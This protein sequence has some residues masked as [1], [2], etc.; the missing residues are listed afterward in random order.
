MYTGVTPTPTVTP[1]QTPAAPPC[2]TAPQLIK[3]KHKATVPK[4]RV[5]LAW[6]GVACAESYNVK[7]YLKK[8]D[9]TLIENTPVSALNY[10]TIA[11][12]KGKTYAW[13]VQACNA[14]GCGPF[15]TARKFTVAP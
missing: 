6:E 10:K 7:V 15:S 2:T 8:L 14:I 12:Q 13:H 9:G 4:R 11:L 3:P 1:T 5:K